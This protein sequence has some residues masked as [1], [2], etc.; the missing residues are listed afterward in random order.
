MS[1]VEDLSGRKFGM[2]TVIK[3]V[4]NT[5]A[6]KACFLCRCSCENKT[7]RAVVGASLKNGVSLNCGCERVKKAIE[8]GHKNKKEPNTYKFYDSCVEGFDEE[9]NSFLIDL[10]D[11]E[12]VSQYRWNFNTDYWK[13]RKNKNNPYRQLHR[14][15]MKAKD[16]EIVDHINRNPN[17]NRKE[18][19]RICNENQNKRNRSLYK[20]NKSGFTGVYFNKN[21]YLAYI[22]VNNKLIRLG[23]FVNKD[24]AIRIRLEAETKHFGEFAPQKHLVELYNIQS[25]RYIEEEN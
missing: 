12:I 25:E 21:K 17:D 19:L 13:R 8:Q 22:R 5:S 18:N 7:E 3:R 11:Y 1:K 20:N 16:D 14:M 10:E 24:D 9:G 2:W 15:I 4:E 23:S 6:G